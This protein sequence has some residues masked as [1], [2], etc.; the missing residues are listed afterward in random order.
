MLTALQKG[1]PFAR[2]PFEELSRG[3]GCSEADLMGFVKDSVASGFARRFGAV[4][5]ARRIGYSS[6]LCCATVADPDG[7]A[8][9]LRTAVLFTDSLLERHKRRDYNQSIWTIRRL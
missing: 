4:F 9:P 8:A 2:R 5:D 3:I 7:A 1:I 6:A